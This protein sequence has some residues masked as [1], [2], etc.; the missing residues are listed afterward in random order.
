MKCI[1]Q[2]ADFQEYF[3]ELQPTYAIIGRGNDEVMTSRYDEHQ[4]NYTGYDS[5]DDMD[6][7]RG[8]ILWQKRYGEIGCS[9]SKF[10]SQGATICDHESIDEWKLG[11]LE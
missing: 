11:F 3:R 7:W 2:I 6:N 8:E 10:Q 4:M 9:G 5:A 1:V